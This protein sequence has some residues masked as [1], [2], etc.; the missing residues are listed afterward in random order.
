MDWPAGHMGK[1][2]SVGSVTTWTSA[3]P[4][5]TARAFSYTASSSS[6]RRAVRPTAPKA[7]ASF[8]KSG[9]FSATEKKRR[10]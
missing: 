7:S 8:A 10:S 3:G 6:G 1:Q 9:F 4:P 5:V 2:F